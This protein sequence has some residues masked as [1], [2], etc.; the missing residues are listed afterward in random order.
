M[1]HHTFTSV[2]RQCCKLIIVSLICSREVIQWHTSSFWNTH[3]PSF[4]WPSS[5]KIATS[6]HTLVSEISNCM[7]CNNLIS[8]RL[9]INIQEVHLQT[10]D[11]S[12]MRLVTSSKRSSLLD[13][14]LK[15]FVWHSTSNH[16]FTPYKIYC[17]TFRK[18]WIDNLMSNAKQNFLI[19]GPEARILLIL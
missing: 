15:D 5:L 18:V 19:N 17:S 4:S 14:W 2:L 7:F 3:K 9:Q 6:S 10:S 13:H 1:V 12:T 11:S 8:C 16:L